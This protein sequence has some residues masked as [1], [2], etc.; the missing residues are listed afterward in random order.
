VGGA[1]L[2]GV[3]LQLSAL[4]DRTAALPQT[5]LLQLPVLPTRWA[6][7]TPSAMHSGVVYGIAAAVRDFIEAWWQQFPSSPV[8]IAGGD[9]QLLFDAIALQFPHISKHLQIDPHLIFWGMYLTAGRCPK[10]KRLL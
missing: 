1:I 10:F 6:L 2:P 5:H 7:D 8:T 9:R 4:A 3:G